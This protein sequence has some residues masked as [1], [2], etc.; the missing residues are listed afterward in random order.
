M[1]SFNT[2][3]VELCQTFTATVETHPFETGWA[4]EAI[5]FVLTDAETSATTRVDLRVQ[6]SPDGIRWIDEGTVASLTGATHDFIRVRHFGGFLRLAGTI[7]DP[8][9]EPGSSTITVRLALKG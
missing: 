8:A 9:A 4:D 3:V 2:S 1:K 5:F 6:I 7:H